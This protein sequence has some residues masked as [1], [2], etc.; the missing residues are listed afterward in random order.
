[1]LDVGAQ[2]PDF[3][4]PGTGGE[5]VRLSEVF[6]ARAATVLAFYVLDFTPG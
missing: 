3:K 1:M 4:L 2:A 5:E 6:A